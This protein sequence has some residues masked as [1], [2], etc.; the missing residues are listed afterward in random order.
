MREKIIPE[1]R[2]SLLILLEKRRYS[3]EARSMRMLPTAE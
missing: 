3:V 2:S 1:K